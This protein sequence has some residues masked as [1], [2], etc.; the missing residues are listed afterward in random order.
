MTPQMMQIV[1]Q[2]ILGLATIAGV[3]MGWRVLFG[4]LTERLR[5]KGAELVPGTG[6]TRKA[7]D[8]VQA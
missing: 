2:T 4:Y 8:E 3:F 7:D 6:I 1:S 5:Y